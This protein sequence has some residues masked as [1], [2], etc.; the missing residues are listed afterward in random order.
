NRQPDRRLRVLVPR[1][2]PRLETDF[3]AISHRAKGA[4]LVGR[5]SAIA[6]GR[7]TRFHHYARVFSASLLGVSTAEDAVG[8]WHRVAG[9]EEVLMARRLAGALPILQ[10]PQGVV[11]TAV[12]GLGLPCCA[13]A[14]EL[15]NLIGAVSRSL[16]LR[17]AI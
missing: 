16:H 9:L 3:R 11:C 1:P 10:R 13:G 15:T 12:Y 6:T 2:S 4:A 17:P 14:A 8:D 5:A 7:S